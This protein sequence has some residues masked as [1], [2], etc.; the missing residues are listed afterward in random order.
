MQK[1]SKLSPRLHTVFTKPPSN[2]FLHHQ[3]KSLQHPSFPR[4]HPDQAN[5]S[6]FAGMAPPCRFFELRIQMA[7]R[8]VQQAI[9]HIE[10]GKGF[11]A[12]DP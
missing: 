2:T 6:M 11:K 12:G 8:Q 1:R 3:L 10:I 4:P 9:S 5:R 7:A